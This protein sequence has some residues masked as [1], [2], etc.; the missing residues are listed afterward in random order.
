MKSE[1][2]PS[3]GKEDTKNTALVQRPMSDIMQLWPKLGE[4]SEK[5]REIISFHFTTVN[6]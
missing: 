6:T 2:P 5:A 3:M 1:L 4:N